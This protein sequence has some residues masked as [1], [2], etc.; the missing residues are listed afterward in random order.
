MLRKYGKAL[1]AALV[2]V[3]TAV[4]AAVS[5]GHVTQQEDIQIAIA[6]ATALNVYLVPAVPDW[7]WAKTVVGVI[8]AV[9]NALTTLI[10][11]GIQPADWTALILAALT[12]VGVTLAPAVSNTRPPTMAEPPGSGPRHGVQS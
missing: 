11:G 12:A 3:V 7:P 2:F 9:L 8:L 1:A 6:A 5:D 10:V 4:Q